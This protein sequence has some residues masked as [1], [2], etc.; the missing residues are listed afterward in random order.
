MDTL[1]ILRSHASG[2]IAAP[3]LL[4]DDDA[5][6]LQRMHLWL[7]ALAEVRDGTRM[8]RPHG[9]YLELHLLICQFQAA[10]LAYCETKH[11][12]R[13]R[14]REAVDARFA[15]L[16]PPPRAT[17][18]SVEVNAGAQDEGPPPKRQRPSL[19]AQITAAFDHH[20]PALPAPHNPTLVAPRVWIRLKRSLL[21]LQRRATALSDTI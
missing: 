12:G 4:Q 9:T 11:A 21:E 16:C 14:T 20:E 8:P 17:M 13:V 18:D 10:R 5:A 2:E 19:R 6:L 3:Y 15:A 7:S 1:P